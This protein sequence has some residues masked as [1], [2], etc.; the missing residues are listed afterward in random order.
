[1]TTPFRVR[2]IDHVVIRANNV[3]VMVRFYSEVLGCVLERADPD[4]GLYQLRA[5]R[6]LVDLVDMRSE[7][8]RAGG[9]APGH[10]GRNMD[11]LCLGVDPFDEAVLRQHLES[12]GVTPGKVF[13]RYGAEGQGP[14]MYIEDPEH[15]VV[16]LKGPPA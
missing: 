2:G 9:G 8:G 6:S 5:G 14:S 7:L 10:D 3:G 4:I 1:M 12:R 15:N 11:H 16:E 13:Q